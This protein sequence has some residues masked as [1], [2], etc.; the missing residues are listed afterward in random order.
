MVFV[1]MTLVGLLLAGAVLFLFL[2]NKGKKS[3]SKVGAAG[4]HSSPARAGPDPRSQPRATA[5]LS[6]QSSALPPAAPRP[7][8]E[9]Q[10]AALL[11]AQQAAQTNGGRLQPAAPMPAELAAFD[12]QRAEDLPPERQ[13]TLLDGLRQTPPPSRAFHQLISPQFVARASSSELSDLVI[14]ESQVAA[15]VLVVVN[16]A[17]YS[18]QSPVSS[19]GQAVTFLGLNSVRGICLRHMLSASFKADSPAQQRRFDEIWLASAVASE[20]SFRLAQQLRLPDP[21]A[22]VTHVVLSFLGHS[23]TAASMPRQGDAATADP[24]SLLA[25]AA[26]QQNTLGAP[27]AELGGLML[28]QWALPPSLI[29]DVLDIDRVLVT[30]PNEHEAGRAAA[31]AVA[32]LSARLGEKLARGEAVDLSLF[33]PRTQADADFYQLGA[34]LDALPALARLLDVLH[35]PELTHAVQALLSGLRTPA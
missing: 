16:S 15:K 7:S 6:A 8:F 9:A 29:T 34:Y 23:V 28:R 12:W 18:L 24:Q 32:Y 25:R 27:A 35:S 19:I 11:A 5:T 26:L 2:S 1:L 14:G 3:K 31:L 13:Q 33:D 22:L 30:P 10:A 4:S 17:A 20:L 21:G